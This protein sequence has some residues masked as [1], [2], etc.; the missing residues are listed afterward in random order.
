[1]SKI[2][3]VYWLVNASSV[4]VTEPRATAEGV[5]KPSN[6]SYSVNVMS[7]VGV[8]W[9]FI[10]KSPLTSVIAGDPASNWKSQELVEPESILVLAPGDVGREGDD[11][12]RPSGAGRRDHGGQDEQWDG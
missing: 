4:S 11:Q 3:R 2:T 12:A 9:D 1:M 6:L 7:E 10:T 8:P 5:W